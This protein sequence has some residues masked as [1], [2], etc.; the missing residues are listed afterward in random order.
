MTQNH[1]YKT[2]WLCNVCGNEDVFYLNTDNTDRQSVIDEACE[3]HAKVMAGGYFCE[4][5]DGK[6][7]QLVGINFTAE[8]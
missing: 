6:D 8:G 4:H 2:K 5:C 3:L 7:F 1:E